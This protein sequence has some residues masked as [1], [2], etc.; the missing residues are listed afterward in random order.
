MSSKQYRDDYINALISQ[1]QLKL[2]TSP[3]E[4]VQ[5][6]TEQYLALLSYDDL[7]EYDVSEL[8]AIVVTQW[9]LIESRQPDS[10][11][12]RVHNPTVAQD[13]W[14]SK[15]TII[16]LSLNDMPFLVDSVRMAINRLGLSLHAIIHAGGIRYHRDAKGH[17]IEILPWG[18]SDSLATA[19]A[20]IYVAV[21]KTTDKNVLNNITTEI[22]S[23]LNDVRMS[24]ADWQKM[25]E[26]MVQARDELAQ[27]VAS[28]AASERQEAQAFLTWLL[29]NHFTFLGYRD[30]ELVGEGQQRALKLLPTTGLGVLRQVDDNHAARMLADMT[31]QAVEVM[32]SPQPLIIAKTNTLATVHRPVYTDY[33][34][35]KRFNTEGKLI[36]EQRFIGLFTS[37]AYQA[38]PYTI[39][40]LRNK[41]SKIIE[42]KQLLKNSHAYKTILDIIHDF[43]RNDLFEGDIQDLQTIISG[44]FNLQE[45]HRVRVFLRKDIY[46]RYVTVLVYL[47]KQYYTHELQQKIKGLLEQELD[48]KTNEYNTHFGES[49]LA[50]VHY[51]LRTEPE[52]S[53]LIDA[54]LIEKKI[55][56]LVTSWTE[57][58]EAILVAKQGEEEGL[59]QFYEYQHAF[60]AGYR[61]NNTPTVAAHDID[62]LDKLHATSSDI[63]VALQENATQNKWTLKVYQSDRLASLS[64]IMPILNNLSVDVESEY[65]YSIKLADR[66]DW[67]NEFTLKPIAAKGEFS[68][69]K[70]NFEPLFLNVWRGH[71]ENDGFNGLVVLAELTGCEITFIRA[72]AKYIRQIGLPYSQQYIE[73][74]FKHYPVL[75]KK[76]VDLFVARFSPATPIH[77]T[78]EIEKNILAELDTVTSLDEDKI[79]RT[80]LTLIKAMIRTNYFQPCSEENKPYISFKFKSSL[81][82]DLPKPHPLFE[83]FVYS[84]RFEAIHLRGGKVARGGLRWSDRPEDFRTEV[85]GLMKAQQVKNSVIVPTG[86]K[87]GFVVKQLKQ[88]TTRESQQAEVISCY[89]NFIRGLLD[90]TDNYVDGKIISPVDMVRYDED[91]PYLV[92]AADKGTATFS[93]IANGISAEY[94][95]WLQ[96]A[97]ASGGQ[98]GYDHKKMAITARGAWVSVTRHFQRL[99]HDIHTQSFTV[100]GIGDMSGD[101]FGNGMLYCNTIKLVAAFDHRHIFIDPNPDTQISF[102][103]RARLFALPRSSWADYNTSLISKGG[104]VFARTD[105]SIAITPEVKSLLDIQDD[106]L[107]PTE[108]IKAILKAPVDLLWNGG[109]GTYVKATPQTHVEAGDRSNDAVRVNGA[110]LRCRVVGEG[111]NLGFTQAGRIEYALKNGCI[112]SD[113]IDNSAGVDCSDKEVNLKIF[114]NKLVAEKELS[115]E[116]RNQLLLEM[117]EQVGTLVLSDNKKQTLA[118]ELARHQA[119]EQVKLYSDLISTYE[120]QNILDRALEALPSTDILLKRMQQG[121]GLTAPEIAVLT[122]Y[123]KISLKNYLLT[124]SLLDE[125]VFQPYL[126]TAFPAR[127][128]TLY[129]EVLSH[130]QLRREII[131]TQLS[132]EIVNQIGPTFIYEAQQATQSDIADIVRAYWAA[133]ELLDMSEHWQRIDNL[134]SDVAITS[135]MELWI[136]LGESVKKLAFNLLSDKLKVWYSKDWIIENKAVVQ[137]VKNN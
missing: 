1:V 22:S 6:F 92:V 95:F 12:V 111:G 40:L 126:Y 27:N 121:V 64:D 29:D 130:H 30:Y 78:D 15:H 120:E 41:I 47:P 14:T 113:F 136:Q 43:P 94:H 21:D 108:L 85:L 133:R 18:T 84:T 7:N 60:S 59:R 35:V 90:I 48:A 10:I 118:I 70:I 62:I 97:F 129:Y 123:S 65:P 11:V 109:I 89:Q 37:S 91:D 69:I 80:Y 58:L 87:G 101:V 39:P 86:A 72:L 71:F 127:V 17:I 128:V 61:E 106:H 82:P 132:N 16:M 105:K 115:F 42:S 54:S 55:I 93:D 4:A 75:S 26:K 32:L 131:A 31:P 98:L 112:F 116:Q 63:F 99:G 53:A 33:I 88:F 134:S 3:K 34:G 79:F 44:I 46:G 74:A 76:I 8:V 49:V 56:E 20:P 36:G 24:V 135:K 25:R 13:G 67:I 100:V 50:R 117:T 9:H 122:S 77:A 104:G 125:P 52:K 110:D 28:I 51:V 73:S 124:T 102:N 2:P 45:R 119:A 38:E 96:D 68:Q 23:A 107:I 5:L 66:T 19:E 114:L 103:E 57:Q 83:I 81:I 137:T